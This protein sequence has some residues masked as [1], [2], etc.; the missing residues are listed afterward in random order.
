MDLF[1]SFIYMLHWLIT[2]K[3]LKT[4]NKATT[5]TNVTVSRI[6]FTVLPFLS[7]TFHFFF[8]EEIVSTPA[9]FTV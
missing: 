5:T 4:I 6:F 3:W 9:L 1:M 7:N 2:I 8:G